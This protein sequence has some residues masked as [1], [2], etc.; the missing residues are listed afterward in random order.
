MLMM[1]MT[2]LN[3]QTLKAVFGLSGINNLVCRTMLHQPTLIGKKTIWNILHI[4][5]Y[6]V[7]NIPFNLL[8]KV[9]PPN[10]DLQTIVSR[11]ETFL[12]N[13]KTKKTRN[14]RGITPSVVFSFCLFQIQTQLSWRMLCLTDTLEGNRPTVDRRTYKHKTDECASRQ[15][16]CR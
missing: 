9:H 1:V 6:L 11:V 10:R 7:E 12:S 3:R 13:K 2:E 5:T 15:K 14:R 16:Q 8:L 4:V